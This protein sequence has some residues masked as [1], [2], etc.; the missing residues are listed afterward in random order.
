MNAIANTRESFEDWYHPNF[1]T[2]PKTLAWE[3]WKQSRKDALEEAAK[4]CESL[5]CTDDYDSTITRLECAQQ[6]RSLK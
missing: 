5:A 3:A 6:I 1:Y 2:D 4:L